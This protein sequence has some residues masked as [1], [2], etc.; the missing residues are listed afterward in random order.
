MFT[1]TLK[2]KLCKKGISRLSPIFNEDAFSRDDSSD[3]HIFYEKDRFVNHID[4]V[5]METVELLIGD[6]V[7]ENDPVILDLM[8]GWDSHIPESVKASETTGLGLN[9]NELKGNKNLTRYMLH[10]INSDPKLPFGENYFDIVINSL[11]V[12]YMTK[13]LEMFHEV[14]RV[15]KPGGLFLVIFSN[16]MFPT[17]AVRVWKDSSETERIIL[18]EEYFQGS[19]MFE[20]PAKFISK[21]KDRPK[22][23]KYYEYC[24]S[25]DPVYALY[26]EKKGGKPG[27][28]KRPIPVIG[29]DKNRR[30]ELEMKKKEIKDTLCCPHCGDKLQKWLVPDNPFV[31]SW[32]NEFMYICF[33]DKC[34]YYTGGLD[35][36]RREGNSGAYRL[37]YNP[38]KDTCNPIPVPNSKALREGIIDAD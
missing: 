2:D 18:V 3:D 32:D 35:F 37:M 22:E 1:D 30:K 24:K 14:A 36:F 38:E 11:S 5:A 20:K 26:A 9:E 7:I 34:S 10:D 6:L 12:D 29:M 33:N 16:R 15:L 4:K 31:C 13:P 23:D 27:R 19:G 28:T 8:A 21:G 25:S 17:K